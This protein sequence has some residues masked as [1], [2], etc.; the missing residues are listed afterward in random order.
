[1]IIV[2]LIV[3]VLE[4]RDGPFIRPHPAFWRLIL[5]LSVVYQMVLVF[6]LFQ[7]ML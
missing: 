7:V 3:A 5:A 1:M 4:F 6:I 2:F